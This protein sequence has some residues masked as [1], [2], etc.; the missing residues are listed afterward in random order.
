VRSALFAGVYAGIS[1]TGR[2]AIMF[3]HPSSAQ[4]CQPLV[5]GGLWGAKLGAIY[6]HG[7]WYTYMVYMLYND[8][9]WYT[10]Y[11]MVYMV[12][13]HGIW[14]T[15]MV[16]MVYMSRRRDTPFISDG[17]HNYS[18]DALGQ[19]QPGW[20]GPVMAPPGPSHGGTATR[21][22]SYYHFLIILS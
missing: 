9:Q 8:I 17:G 14:Y 16:Y 7:I 11:T 13:Q 18:S 5:D 1:A 19:S 21:P 10:W 12:Y 20:A 6:Q 22:L 4:A 2:R 3:G 15:Y